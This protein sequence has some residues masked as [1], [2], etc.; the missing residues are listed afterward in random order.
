MP[1]RYKRRRAPRRR[2]PQPKRG[3]TSEALSNKVEIKYE[4]KV[5]Y[6]GGRGRVGRR[7]PAK[8]SLALIITRLRRVELALGNLLSKDSKM[9]ADELFQLGAALLEARNAETQWDEDVVP[10]SPGGPAEG[11]DEAEG[12]DGA[13]S[14]AFARLEEA[15]KA[16]AEAATKDEEN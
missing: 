12:D 13:L 4:T 11:Q 7:P 16:F 9:P 10:V 8:R 14:A 5:A 3:P 15:S 6:P 1:G 2:A